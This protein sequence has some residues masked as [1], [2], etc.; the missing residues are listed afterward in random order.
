[1]GTDSDS[2]IQLKEF[3]RSSERGP[4]EAV[5]KNGYVS[6]K[7]LDFRASQSA[8]PLKL[9]HVGMHVGVVSDFR[10]RQSAAPLKRLLEG[11]QH[12]SVHDFRTRQSAAPLKPIDLCVLFKY[13]GLF[14]CLSS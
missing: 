5:S 9:L 13:P 2:V 4:I 10:A 1:M 6:I 7:R 8:A 12:V 11:R 14:S 3:P